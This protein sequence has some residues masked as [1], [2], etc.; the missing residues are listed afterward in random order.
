MRSPT[1]SPSRLF[2]AEIAG[3]GDRSK[4][5]IEV[6]SSVISLVCNTD[7]DIKAL[8][9]ASVFHHC[10]CIVSCLES[11]RYWHDVRPSVCPSI[12]DGRA[13]L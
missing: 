2:L 6:I 5:D 12:L 8:A 3:T 7:T 10:N 11:S 9:P 1:S 13:L 4:C